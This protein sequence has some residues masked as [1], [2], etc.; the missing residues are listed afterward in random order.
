[1][2]E[3]DLIRLRSLSNLTHRSM[4]PEDPQFY[5]VVI[6]TLTGGYNRKNNSYEIYWSSD[7]STSW[8]SEPYLET[9]N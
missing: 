1:M 7:G 2:K 5:G 8:H 9:V 6:K 4:R 3:G